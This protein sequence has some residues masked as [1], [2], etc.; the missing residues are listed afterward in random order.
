MF[1]ISLGNNVTKPYIFCMSTTLYNLQ[2]PFT[3]IFQFSVRTP[4]QIGQLLPCF[5]QLRKLILRK[6]KKFSVSA[7]VRKEPMSSY[8]ALEKPQHLTL[9]QIFSLHKLWNVAGILKFKIISL[10]SQLFLALQS[11]QI[12]LIIAVRKIQCQKQS[13][14]GVRKLTK[15]YQSQI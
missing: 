1:Y 8:R 7:K 15:Q 12:K 2:R 3:Y 11:M 9:L 10:P 13:P 5:S 6:G 14:K 4:K